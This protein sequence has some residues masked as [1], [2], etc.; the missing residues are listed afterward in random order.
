[1]TNPNVGASGTQRTINQDLRLYSASMTDFIRTELTA[2][3]RDTA[4]S[5]GLKMF[6]QFHSFDNDP[7][8]G[9]N[10]QSTS[11]SFAW[12][13]QTAKGMHTASLWTATLTVRQTLIL[14]TMKIWACVRLIPGL[15]QVIYATRDCQVLPPVCLVSLV[16]PQMAS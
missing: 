13:S 15:P 14:G 5:I 2:T 11:R 6:S 3:T 9:K 1:M 12:P 7:L 10:Y 4:R 8:F 16:A